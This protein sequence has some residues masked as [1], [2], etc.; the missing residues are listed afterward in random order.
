M[1]DFENIKID[2]IDNSKIISLE[3]KVKDDTTRPIYVYC[4]DFGNNQ[5]YIGE[6]INIE[7]RMKQHIYNAINGTHPSRIIKKIA[8]DNPKKV[9]DAFSNPLIL[10]FNLKGSKKEALI[11]E[12]IF[13]QMFIDSGYLVLGGNY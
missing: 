8:K 4:A 1:I 2:G 5:V 3:E 11:K 12:N 13:Q 10:H 6:T 7:K 9:I